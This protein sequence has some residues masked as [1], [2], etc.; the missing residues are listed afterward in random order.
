VNQ[1]ITLPWKVI[2]SFSDK[3]GILTGQITAEWRSG[4]MLNP[5]RRFISDEMAFR[6]SSSRWVG[7]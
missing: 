1:G 2:W 5:T 4:K 6:L 7:N 3:L